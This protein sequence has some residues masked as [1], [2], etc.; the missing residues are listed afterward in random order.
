MCAIKRVK[1]DLRSENEGQHRNIDISYQ[2]F[3]A[4]LH[5]APVVLVLHALTGNSNVAGDTGWWKELVAEG[6]VIDLCRYTVV[7]F[8]IP[9][10]EYGNT[11]PI[12]DYHRLTTRL[13]ASLFWEAIDKL[14]I[15]ELYAV[16]G[17]SLGGS[18]GWEMAFLRPQF[19]RHLIPIAC[20]LQSSDW[21]IANVMVQE[22]ILHNSIEPVKQA[23]KHAML[24]Y[25]SPES[26]DIKFAR[27]RNE[28]EYAVEDWLNYHGR[29]L[30]KRFSLNAYKAMN[31]L[32]RTIGEDRRNG[33]IIAFAEACTSKIHCIA[34]DTDYL[35]TRDEQHRAYKL[36]KKYKEDITFEEIRSVHGHDAFLIEYDQIKHILNP[37]FR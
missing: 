7:A 3:G 15:S 36:I 37:I 28:T 21:L 17:G 30:D 26:F 22:H 18:I 24:L 27:K 32:L 13:V 6:A 34:I 16:I 8:N 11:S 35:F 33:D 20:S 23:R 31:R 12:E 2:I 25:R 4:D 9:G 14:C 5:S 29:A 1:C 10:N 19:I